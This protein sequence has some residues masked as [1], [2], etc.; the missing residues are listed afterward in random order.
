MWRDTLEEPMM[1]AFGLLK[2]RHVVSTEALKVTWLNEVKKDSSKFVYDKK[3][4]K[5]IAIPLK[6]VIVAGLCVMPVWEDNMVQFHLKTPRSF[7]RNA[8]KHGFES[9]PPVLSENAHRVTN[10]LHSHS[11]IKNCQDEQARDILNFALL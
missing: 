8:C 2:L 1:A 6:A 3:W 5:K 4:P 11:H 9:M 7:I 10:K